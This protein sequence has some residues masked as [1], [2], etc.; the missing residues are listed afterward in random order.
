MHMVKGH[1]EGITG[2]QCL[3]IVMTDDAADKDDR[4]N[5]WSLQEYRFRPASSDLLPI[6]I[7]NSPTFFPR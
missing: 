7:T 6:L 4:V 5:M 1:P 2:E 3:L